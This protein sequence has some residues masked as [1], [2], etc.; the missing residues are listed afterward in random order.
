MNTEKI[1]ELVNILENSGLSVLEAEKDGC[2]IRLE[3]PGVYNGLQQAERLPAYSTE[4]NESE[5]NTVS[6]SEDTEP[7]CSAGADSYEGTPV[8][9]PMVGVFYSKPSP[10]SEPFVKP[11]DR[12][13]AGQT[14]CIVEAMKLMNEI[15]AEKDGIIEAVLVSDEELVEFG[16]ELF[17][18]K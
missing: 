16:Q 15:T 8:L 13:T 9:S 14:V 3:K 2:R 4:K 12:V 17:Y 1:K 7:A 10:E 5:E 18:I 6:E 11:G